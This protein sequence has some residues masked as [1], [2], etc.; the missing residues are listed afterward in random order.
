MTPLVMDGDSS[1]PLRLRAHTL[2]CLQGFRGMGYSSGFVENMTAIHRI[3]S[4]HPE[5]LIEVLDAPDAVC[6]ACPYRQPSGCT[7][8]GDRS[9]EEMKDQDHAVLQ[10]LGLQVGSR[11]RWQDVLDRIRASV[12]GDDLPTV[13]GTCRWL[14]LGFCGE[15]ITRLRRSILDPSVRPH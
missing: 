4:D 9:E 2:L 5:T 15:G 12:C 7:L 10:M 3:L 6:G 11:L 14:P 1:P 13:C 8:N